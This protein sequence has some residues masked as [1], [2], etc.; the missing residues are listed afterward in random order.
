MS[1]YHNTLNR[2]WAV[3]RR[4]AF[5]RDGWR[6]QRC[7]RAGRLEVDHIIPLA[8]GGAPYDL[9]NLQTLCR[10]CHIRKTR[11]DAE[12]PVPENVRCWR[13]LVGGMIRE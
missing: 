4:A 11:E 8:T 6:C 12:G 7:G 1:R 9:A 2:R 10:A 5:D 3:S 13:D